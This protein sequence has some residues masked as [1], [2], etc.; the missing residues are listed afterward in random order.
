MRAAAVF[1]VLGWLLTVLAA[2]MLVPIA[3]AVTLDPAPVVEAFLF[4]AVVIGFL[5]VNMVIASRARDLVIG[6]RQGL[7]LFAA[8]WLT[9]PLAAAL[10]FYSAGFPATLSAAVF[11]ATS[12]FTTTGA[13]V[14]GEISAVPRAIIVWRGLL[15]WLGGLTSLV[16]LAALLGPLWEGGGSE[17]Q[18]HV[19]GRSENRIFAQIDE[20]LRMVVPIYLLLTLLCFLGLMVSGL[21]AFDALCLS[22][23]AVSTGGFMPRDGTIALYG[24]TAAELVLTVFMVL[25]AVNLLWV[26]ALFSGRWSSVREAREPFLIIALV[27]FVGAALTAALL[28]TTPLT[29]PGDVLDTFV[30][31]LAAAASLVTTT[32]FMVSERAQDLVPY[33]LL[34]I[35]V[36][37]GGGA[38]STAGG[39]KIFRVWAMFRQVGRELQLLVYPHGVRP[40]PGGDEARD[41]RLIMAIWAT[42]VAFT[43][44]IAGLAVLLATSGLSF[45]SALLAA[46]SVISNVGP[47]YEMGRA[48]AFSAAPAFAAMTP[49]SQVALCGG[50]ILGRGEVLVILSLLG[51]AYWR[52]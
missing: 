18:P 8:I 45:E 47:A 1:Y 10:P 25:G 12:G 24:S 9:V 17:R 34:L 11:E 43:V 37:V 31:S 22:L 40:S 39:L 13:T 5:G 4:P 46:A 19:T 33:T 14:I 7:M 49:G 50:M 23:S 29:G 36:V 27:A 52:D 38:F 6:R 35:V 16:L 42:F 15:Q 48:S 51:V 28:G 30:L 2:A 41:D 44:T 3:F 20:A 32:G 21:A 26:Q